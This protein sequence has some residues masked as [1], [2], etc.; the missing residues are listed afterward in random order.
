MQCRLVLDTDEKRERAVRM[1]V[2]DPRMILSIEDMVKGDCLFAATGVTTR[3]LVWGV[4]L[5][6]YVIETET[7][8][9]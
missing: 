3:A 8:V 1:G 7:I 2:T 5:R 9:M 6:K 4:K